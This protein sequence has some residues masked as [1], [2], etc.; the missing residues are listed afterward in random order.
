[1]SGKIV[2]PAVSHLGS[3]ASALKGV[4]KMALTFVSGTCTV[5]LSFF[6]ALLGCRPELVYCAVAGV[7]PLEVG[8]QILGICLSSKI[9]TGLRLKSICATV[10]VAY[11]IKLPYCFAPTN[12]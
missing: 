7:R 11:C 6:S 10:I 4:G 2:F 1:M 9:G 5:R 3:A 8:R 12:R